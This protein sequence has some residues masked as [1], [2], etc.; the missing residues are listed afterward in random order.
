MKN[1]KIKKLRALMKKHKIDAYLLPGTDPHQ[2]EYVPE[3]WNRI[4]FISGF[5][6]ACGNI[7]VTADKAM[8]WTD[9]RH[10]IQVRQQVAGSPFEGFV[11]DPQHISDFY[12]ELNWIREQLPDKKNIAIGVDP[13][14]INLNQVESIKETLKHHKK[15]SIKY[16][17]E[18]LIDAVW[19]NQPSLPNSPVV[20]RDEKTENTPAYK[21]IKT[22]QTAMKE[23]N[24]D[25]HV[26][27]NL[28]SIAR[29]LNIRGSDVEFTPLAISYLILEQDKA[30]WFIDENRLPVG[31]KSKLPES[32]K[33]LPYKDFI[34]TLKKISKNKRILLDPCEISQCVFNN[35]NKKAK[36][37]RDTSLINPIKAVKNKFELKKM[38]E[39]TIRD[40]LCLVKTIYWLKTEIKK[41]KVTEW[42]VCEKLLGFRKE[43]KDFMDL[44]FPTIVSYNSNGPIIHYFTTKDS[45]LTIKPHGLTLIDA[46]AQYPCATTDMTRTISCGTVTDKMKENYTRVLKGHVNIA[47][48]KFP[49]GTRGYN[50]DALARQF[51]WETGLVYRHGTGHGVGYGTCVHE[52]ANVGI[53]PLKSS[54]L[55]E[56]M[57]LTNEP[58]F[59]KEDEY[60]IRIENTIAVEKDDELTN[61]N[62]KDIFLKFQQFTLCPY[63]K[64]LIVLEML[65]RDE[66]K[67]INEYHKS[68]MDNLKPQI[69]DYDLLNWLEQACAPMNS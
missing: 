40:C 35:I 49:Y 65:N 41:G 44:S 25:T 54:I 50:L 26:I 47:R 52:T 1:E 8:V 22:V 51:L 7:T 31:Y 12:P 2:D 19:D 11:K 57:T 34:K 45:A 17:E 53:G 32:V 30:L 29:L 13:L 64:E 37:R 20:I 43:N 23:Q 66:I 28:E 4:K 63:E 46:G 38:F 24:I 10:E 60:G 18:N 6:G 39:A 9:A 27:S 21:K 55:E 16:I 59:Y 69:K 56:G 42:D 68:V 33:I 48:L 36:I 58:G 14:L 15:I 67:W 5:D 62:G 3:F 61:I